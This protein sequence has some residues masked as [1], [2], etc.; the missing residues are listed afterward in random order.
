MAQEG[1]SFTDTG[2]TGCSPLAAPEPPDTTIDSGPSGSTEA[3]AASFAF[4]AS[5]PGSTFECSLDGAA[6]ARVL[7]AEGAT[8]ASRW[9][10]TPSACAR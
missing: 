2:S 8:P 7:L 5:K 1:K 9:A 3:T 6:F 4:S 10:T